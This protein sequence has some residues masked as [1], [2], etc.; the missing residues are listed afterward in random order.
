MQHS[1]LVMRLVGIEGEE[2]SGIVGQAGVAQSTNPLV[3][4]ALAGKNDSPRFL[5]GLP[6][7]RLLNIEAGGKDDDAAETQL[8]RG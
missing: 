6:Y 7:G 1:L 8:D 5:Q 4:L 3:G 2:E